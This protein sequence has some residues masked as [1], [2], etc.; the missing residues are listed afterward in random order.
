MRHMSR[1]PPDRFITFDLETA[2][3]LPEDAEPT[4]NMPLG[5]A[6]AACRLPSGEVRYWTGGTAPTPAPKLTTEECSRLVR[7]LH[8]LT[9]DGTPLVTWNGA[10]FDFLVLAHESGQW[11]ECAKLALRHID[12]MF[13]FFC[14]QGYPI[15]LEAAAA[16]L[17]TRK[18]AGLTG[19]DAPA[20]WAR[21][22]H[23]RVRTYL[24]GD[25]DMLAEVYLAALRNRAIRWRTQRGAIR[26]WPV[27]RFV[28][29]AEARR[30]P[31]PDTSWMSNP[32]PRS[33]FCGWLET[34]RAPATIETE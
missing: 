30:L 7:D 12:V 27:S 2:K 26:E 16:P 1:L 32:I 22:E 29:V 20:A 23:E 9:A 3:V 14:A 31:L 17:G 5:I 15:G 11:R 6:V 19:A 13:H 10:G 8:E 21:G 25:V 18:A 4:A 33:E 24:R 28:T 34:E